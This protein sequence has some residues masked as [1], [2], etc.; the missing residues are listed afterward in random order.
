MPTFSVCE[1][2][3]RDSWGVAV[4]V[5]GKQSR[6]LTGAKDEGVESWGEIEKERPEL[7]QGT[8]NVEIVSDLILCSV[9]CSVIIEGG[10]T[11]IL[12]SSGTG[13]RL[14]VFVIKGGASRLQAPAV[15]CH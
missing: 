7:S 8:S 5:A 3:T 13:V 9:F 12:V 10:Q 11:V 14:E 2:E 15:P 1:E 4:A 6:E